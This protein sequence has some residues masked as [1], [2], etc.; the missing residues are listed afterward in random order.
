MYVEWTERA[1]CNEGVLE[2]V[3]HQCLGA[4]HVSVRVP[5]ARDLTSSTMFTSVDLDLSPDCM[6][7]E[8]RSLGAS[9]PL[10]SRTS[11]P[12]HQGSLRRITAV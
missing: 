7:Q 4:G 12:V 5:L 8:R 9:G 11:L 1:W 2:Q 10:G 6:E 3:C